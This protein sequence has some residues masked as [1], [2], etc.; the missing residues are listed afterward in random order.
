MSSLVVREGD[1]ILPQTA[2]SAPGMAGLIVP[3]PVQVPGSA[4]F[5]IEGHI[6]CVPEDI[7][8]LVVP[9]IGYSAGVF[10]GGFGE[11]RFQVPGHNRARYART[12]S[13]TEVVVDGGLLDL[14]FKPTERATNPSGVEDLTPQYT[15]KAQLIC[16]RGRPVTAGA[17]A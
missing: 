3:R 9:G 5:R 14:T 11:I 6:A 15:G 17:G 8:K 12:R 4:G 10:T 1:S 16:V 7:E 2:V 13:G